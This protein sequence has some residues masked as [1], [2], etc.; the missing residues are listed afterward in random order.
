MKVARKEKMLKV[1]DLL[2][3]CGIKG[4]PRAMLKTLLKSDSG[5]R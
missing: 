4:Q 3:L 1:V 2:D 5:E